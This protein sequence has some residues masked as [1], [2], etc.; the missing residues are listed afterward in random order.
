MVPIINS[1]RTYL[2]TRTGN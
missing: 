2:Q 1:L